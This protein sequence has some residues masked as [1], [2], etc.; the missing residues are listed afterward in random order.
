MVPGIQDKNSKPEISFSIAYSDNF[1]SIVL[2]PAIKVVSLTL[3]IFEKLD[4]N[5]IAIPLI[6]LSLIK[7]F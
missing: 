3:E 1:L 6:P 2:A 4:P 5:L 7:R